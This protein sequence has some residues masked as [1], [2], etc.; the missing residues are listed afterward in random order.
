MV[1]PSTE[2][3]LNYESILFDVAD[4][5]ATIT[6]NRPDQGNSM[7]LVVMRDLMHASITCDEDPGIR[8]VVVTGSGR[9]FSAGGDLA[10]FGATDDPASLI[11]EMTVYF[12]AAVSRFSRMNAPIIAAV[13]GMAAGAGFSFAAACDVTIAA[14]SAR[15]ASQYTA[16]SLSPDGSSTYFVPRM[17]GMKRA[18]ELMLTNRRLSAAEALDWGLVTEVVADDALMG[19]V[20]EIASEFASGATLAYGAVKRLLHDSLSSTLESQMETEA[21]EIARL[22]RSRD[23]QEGVRS[24]LEK[25]APEFRGE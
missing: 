6:F 18:L 11:K 1:G 17:V 23:G 3:P 16:A 10:S 19:R 5:V 4:G 15:F 25:R 13:N 8:A 9:F 21:R 24:F 12:H 22:S 20:G 2:R 14:E 7:D